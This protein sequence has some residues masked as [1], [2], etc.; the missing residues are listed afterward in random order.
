PPTHRPLT[1]ARSASPS[2]DA[3]ASTAERSTSGFPAPAQILLCEVVGVVAYP[4]QS[5]RSPMADLV[6]RLP[7]LTLRD[8]Q[9]L[10]R[11]R[12]GVRRIKTADRRDTVLWET[13]KEVETAESRV[14]ARRASVPRLRY[15]EQL[16]VSQKK[17]DILAAIRD[18]QVVIVAGETGS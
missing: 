7:E 13:A 10:G 18:H 1:P 12:E 15:P 3:S 6:S 11:P 2:G 8:E 14:A 17:D 5:M 9:R 16:P 4:G